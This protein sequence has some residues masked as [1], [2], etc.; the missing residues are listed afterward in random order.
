MSAVV[1]TVCL[2]SVAPFPSASYRP[3]RMSSTDRCCI[4][5][6]RDNLQSALHDGILLILVYPGLT[7]LASCQLSDVPGSQRLN[8]E[9]AFH[10]AWMVRTGLSTF[11]HPVSET[12]QILGASGEM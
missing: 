5:P 7:N 6:A 2:A 12:V 4:C 8:G 9:Q 3:V 11:T 10:G 1:Y